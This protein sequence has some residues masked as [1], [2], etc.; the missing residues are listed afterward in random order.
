M[1]DRAKAIAA[2]LSIE[3]TEPPEMGGSVFRGMGLSD[4]EAGVIADTVLAAIGAAHP[5]SWVVQDALADLARDKGA[6]A[7]RAAIVAWLNDPT[8]APFGKGVG[9]YAK[10]LARGEH[11]KGGEL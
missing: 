11:L 10:C 8:R 3:A 7:E 2:I 4:W 9:Y 5:R 6:L 1:T